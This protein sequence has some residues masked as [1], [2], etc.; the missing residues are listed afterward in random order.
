MIDKIQS[1]AGIFLRGFAM[2]CADVVPGV[3]GGTIAL[4]T[5]IYERV[6]RAITRIDLKAVRLFFSWRLAEFWRH[7][8]GSFLLTLFVGILAAIFTLANSIIW[9][10]E[11]QPLLVWS[12][13]SGLILA[14]AL[15]LQSQLEVGR[16]VPQLGFTLLGVAAV[17]LLSY[18]RADL[19]DPAL[20]LVFGSGFIAIS[21]MMLPGIS[22]SFI[23]L[24]L[25][26]Y[27]PTLAAV[28]SFE[29]DYLLSFALG[30]GCGFLVFSRIIQW[31]LKHY[32]HQTLMF[33]VGLLLGSLTATWPWKLPSD[34]NPV[35]QNLSPSAYADLFGS[36]QLM[37]VALVFLGGVALVFTIEYLGRGRRPEN[38]SQ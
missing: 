22:G 35:G 23:L 24:M 38:E 25:G 1:I 36:A 19:S 26:L 8:D 4:I 15:Y 5:H 16:A 31:M 20:P 34:Q 14:S 3:S 29:L 17:I 18:L 33:L 21:A 7:I 37:G 27:E 6:I 11:N 10:M 12:F 28:K 13:F 30:A 32:H 9:L 2:G